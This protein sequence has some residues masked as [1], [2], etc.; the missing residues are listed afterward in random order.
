M[1]NC[2]YILMLVF[3]CCACSRGKYAVSGIFRKEGET[4]MEVIHLDSSYHYY[5]RE[6]FKAKNTLQENVLKTNVE[7]GD[8]LDKVRIEIEH[9][10]ISSLHKNA[11]YISTIPD[12]YQKYYSANFIADTLINAYDF[13]TFHFGKI[14]EDGESISFV[15]E[16]EKQT[17]TWDIRP[18]INGT[19]PGK[20]S[21]R[22]IAVQRND[23][24]ENVILIN[25]ALEEP[26]VFKKQDNFAI[27]FEKPGWKQ[28][29]CNDASMLCKLAD[30]KIYLHKMKHGYDIY[31]RFN[32]GI[33]YSKD[34][35]IRFD[36]RRTRYPP[37]K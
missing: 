16:K 34:S 5:L 32:K 15:S 37:V 22:E 31:F 1:K 13:S 25:K 28:D 20:L 12:K 17:I 4:P 36:S 27:V 14:A 8:T 7:K 33:N 30:Q 18:F 21:I 24:L 2:I 29:T 26:L 11:I 3:I 6:V 10:L 35:A 19:F 23:L 9:L